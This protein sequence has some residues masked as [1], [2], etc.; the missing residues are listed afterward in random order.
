[1]TALSVMSAVNAATLDVKGEIKIDGKVVIDPQGNLLS[2]DLIDINA[3][4]ES[5]KGITILTAN[6][7]EGQSYVIV[8][9]SDGLKNNSEFDYKNGELEWAGEWFDGEL[10]RTQNN[11]NE[12]FPTNTTEHLRNAPYPSIKIGSTGTALSEYRTKSQNVCDGADKDEVVQDIESI[13][14]LAKT[15]YQQDEFNF[16][17]CILVEQIRS[18]GRIDLKTYCLGQGL[19]EYTTNYRN[20]GDNPS[21]EY[22]L[23]SVEALPADY[24]WQHKILTLNTEAEVDTANAQLTTLLNGKTLYVVDTEYETGVHSVGTITFH[25]N[26]TITDDSTDSGT[27]EVK[28]GLLHTSWPPSLGDTDPEIDYA[29]DRLIEVTDDYMVLKSIVIYEGDSVELF[30]AYFEQEKAEAYMATLPESEVPVTPTPM[31]EPI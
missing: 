14:L 13:S 12:C 9:T 19:V 6:N 5:V 16:D 8:N 22:K 18:W 23:T 10:N 27:W 29:K 11:H 25:D 1:M 3:Y 17:D 4:R 28:D 2:P 24:V 21:I 30:R 20:G 31:P 7:L 15:S 26:G